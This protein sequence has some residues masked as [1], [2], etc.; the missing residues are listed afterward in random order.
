MLTRRRYLE[1]P[2]GWTGD[3]TP[4]Q[5]RDA[6]E[7]LKTAVTKQLP[8]LARR[9]LREEPQPSWYEAWIPRDTGSTIVRRIR[10][11]GIF[12]RQVPIPDA[13][14]DKTVLDF[15]KEIENAIATALSDFEAAVTAKAQP[16][17]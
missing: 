3:P 5:K 13:R 8:S 2:V 10:I 4:E 6:I 12:Q 9:R 14:G 16:P 1:N 17:T 15:M 7:R 11:E